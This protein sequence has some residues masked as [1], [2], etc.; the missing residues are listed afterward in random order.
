MPHIIYKGLALDEVKQI[1]YK[2]V[3]ALS[4]IIDCPMDHFTSEWCS[5]VFVSGGIENAGGYPFVSIHWF[6]RPLNQKIEVATYVTNMVKAL[7][8]QDVCVYFNVL[9]PKCYF[10]NGSH[11]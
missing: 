11:F 9:D 7:G 5:N 1:E 10:E 2:V 3:E 8:Y 6:E 4:Q